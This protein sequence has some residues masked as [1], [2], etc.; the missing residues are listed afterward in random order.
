MTA[1]LNVDCRS[2]VA[3]QKAD[4][5]YRSVPSLATELIHGEREDLGV[6]IPT[7]TL[8]IQHLH[9]AHKLLDYLCDKTGLFRDLD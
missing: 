6:R 1:A 4:R 8:P 9:I 2:I 3:S 7:P 5:C